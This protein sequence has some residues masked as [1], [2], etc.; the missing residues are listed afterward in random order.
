MPWLSGLLLLYLAVP[1]AAFCV[2][3]AAAHSRGFHDPG[4]FP[5]L[6]T[7]VVAA[8]ISTALVTV[9]GV[10]LAYL[11]AR[12]HGRLASATG[13]AVQLPL[14]V[15]PVMSGILLVYVVGPYTAVGRFFGGALT[16]TL[17]G[18][19]LAQTFVAAPFLV[20]TARAAFGVVDPALEDVAATLGHHSL[21]RFLRVALPVAAPGV[22]AGM[23]LAW[24]RA[25]GEYGA[26]V[27]LAYHPTSLPVYTFTQ[28]SASGLPGT[29]APTALALAV[30][31]CCVGLSRAALLRVRRR[32]RSSA[33]ASV[34]SVSRELDEDRPTSFRPSPGAVSL[35]PNVAHVLPAGAPVSFA[36]DQWVGAFH[37]R[38]A[39]RGTTPRLA[40]LGPSGSGKSTLLRCLAG[41]HGVAG[42]TVR[43]GG[44]SVDTVPAPRR[45][46]GYVAQHFALFP[47]L[48]VW[49]QVLFGTDADPVVADAWL[50]RLGLRGLEDR[51]PSE[52]SGGQRQRVALA[53]ALAISPAVLLLDEPFSALDTPVRDELRRE[54]RRVQRETQV[55]TV[56][57]TH[58]PEEAALLA[59]EVLVVAAGRVLQEGRV[60][61]VFGAPRSPDAARLLGLPNAFAAR[62]TAPGT[63]RLGGMSLRAETGDLAPGTAVVWAVSPAA[64]EILP[65]NAAAAT[66][67]AG[68][69]AASTATAAAA[70]AAARGGCTIP[71]VVED[72]ADLGTAV[73]L[74][75]RIAPT[76]ALRARDQDASTIEWDSGDPCAV[77][78]PVVSVSPALDDGASSPLDLVEAG[79][80][81]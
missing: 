36:V 30:A 16:G 78:L 45:R 56:V 60:R 29:M 3:L 64:V 70:T 11:L 79:T 59:D 4:L 49:E 42:G 63:V 17:T 1:V 23:V 80:G 32:R 43:F 38:V 47:H 10:P 67:T 75:V 19:V 20:V 50:E 7:S 44:E 9:L 22:R 33:L 13:V 62:I 24:L 34:A 31:L 5:A 65:V 8:S 26:T 66:S 6:V 37:L 77:V 58:D 27:V 21:G 57:V 76:V 69:T 40:V 39:H 61:D 48:T 71:G 15:P 51:L 14:A 72:A 73:E 35:P 41:L 55:S 12:S 52:L 74:T 81:P 53:Q 46:V 28:F 18:I 25:F 54:L 2:R 68:A